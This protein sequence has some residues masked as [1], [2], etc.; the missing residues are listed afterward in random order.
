MH[1]IGNFNG[2]IFSKSSMAGIGVVI[3]D[4]NGLI[5]SAMS[6]KFSLPNSVIVFK[7]LAA[8]TTV[9]FAKDLG[10]HRLEFEVDSP[11]VNSTLRDSRSSFTP[12]FAWKHY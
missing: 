12:C 8:C 6:Q 3:R 1:L 11:L 7:A 10:L 9:Q 2:A 5:I 4:S